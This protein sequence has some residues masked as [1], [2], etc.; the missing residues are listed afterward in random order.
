MM[1][2]KLKADQGLAFAEWNEIVFGYTDMLKSLEL[3]ARHKSL[4]HSIKVSTGKM[5]SSFVWI[6]F[7][8]YSGADSLLVKPLSD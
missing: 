7:H 5:L 3:L 8:G 4:A 1:T 2:R 6:F